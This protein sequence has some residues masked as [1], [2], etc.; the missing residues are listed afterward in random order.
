MTIDRRQS[1]VPDETRPAGW[2]VLAI[3]DGT[4]EAV[5]ETA[6]Q[7]GIQGRERCI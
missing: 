3:A 5:P 6:A 2:E 7:I 4:R 1:V